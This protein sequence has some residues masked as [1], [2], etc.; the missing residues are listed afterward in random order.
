M[1]FDFWVINGTIPANR[2]KTALKQGK[3]KGSQLANIRYGY[4]AIKYDI[5]GQWNVEDIKKG[6]VIQFVEYACC[7]GSNKAGEYLQDQLERMFKCRIT[8][9][10]D[11]YKEY[12]ERIT[13]KKFPKDPHAGCSEIMYTKEFPKG[14]CMDAPTGL[15]KG[16]WL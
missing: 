4:F 9:D 2:L 12:T 8:M 10:Y 13:G 6:N 5:K 16:F 7:H 14:K 3:I 1:S 15:P 11:E